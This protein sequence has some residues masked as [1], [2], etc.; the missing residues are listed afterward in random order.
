MSSVACELDKGTDCASARGGGDIGIRL[1]EL[2]GRLARVL[3]DAG[4]G[5][6][7]VVAMGVPSGV[8]TEM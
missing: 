4:A 8:A 5:A 2:K 6:V 3:I 1:V 7:L